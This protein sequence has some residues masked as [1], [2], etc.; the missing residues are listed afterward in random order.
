[1]HCGSAG[2]VTL[3]RWR[4]TKWVAWRLDVANA[5]VYSTNSMTGSLECASGQ[6]GITRVEVGGTDTELIPCCMSVFL[7]GRRHP[8]RACVVVRERS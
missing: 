2:F 8:A 7:S 1:M 4:A 6:C 5:A 3:V